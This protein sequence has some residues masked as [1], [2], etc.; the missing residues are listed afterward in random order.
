MEKKSIFIDNKIVGYKKG[1][2]GDGV[3]LLHGFGEN[4]SVWDEQIGFLERNYRVIAPDIPGSGTSELTINVGMEAI[5]DMVKIIA[6][7]EKLG[8]F[9]LIGHSMGGYVTL[10]FAEKYPQLLKG[11]GLFHSTALP[12]DEEKKATRRKGIEFIKKYGADMF[13][14][15]QPG[16]LYTKE[17]Q[18]TNPKLV[19]DFQ[20]NNVGFSNKALIAYYEAMIARPD[21]T[22]VLAHIN[23][24]V[25]F[26]L[27]EQDTIIPLRNILPQTTLPSIS[28]ITILKKSGHM[29]MLEEP[30]A[31]NM[32]INDFL[33]E[34]SIFN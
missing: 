1:G 19:E 24:P 11:C 16:N 32:A 6:E 2:K 21:R 34:M 13:L 20:K 23:V 29:G 3:I 17:T 18:K 15:M 5:A 26:I 30:L 12:D 28:Y 22:R 8:R 31:S 25:L 27:G 9:V 4:N 14:D 7:A 10:A 33:S